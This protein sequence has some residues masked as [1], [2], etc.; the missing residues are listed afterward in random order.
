MV[1]AIAEDMNDPNDSPVLQ[2]PEAG[3]DIRTGDAQGIYDL[4][5]GERLFG[6][7]KEG[8]DLGNGAI[9]S[10]AGAHFPPVEDEFLGNERQ[11]LHGVQSFL[12]RRKLEKV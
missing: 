1:P 4:V 12:S 11:V 3:A 9:D 2:I 7:E 8:M 6:K 10:P 5:R